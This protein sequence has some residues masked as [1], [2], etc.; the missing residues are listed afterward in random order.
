MNA[1]TA[2]IKGRLYSL[3]GVTILE[4]VIYFTV[5]LRNECIGMFLQTFG[6]QFRYDINYYLYTTPTCQLD[7]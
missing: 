7:R 5:L 6:I 3:V 2:M 4:K 1:M